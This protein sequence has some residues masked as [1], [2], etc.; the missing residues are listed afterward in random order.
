MPSSEL[1]EWVAFYRLEEERR[2]QAEREAK[3]E[4]QAK[5]WHKPTRR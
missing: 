4:A 5:K 3:A 1:A 2:E